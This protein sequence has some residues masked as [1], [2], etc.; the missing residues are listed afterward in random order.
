VGYGHRNVQG[1]PERPGPHVRL[2]FGSKTYDE[3]N[4]IEPGR[5]HGWPLVEA[6]APTG[7]YEPN[8][9]WTPTRIASPS[10][11]AVL[12]EH[13]YVA[14]LRGQ[15]L[16]RL[17]LDG[18]N[19]RRLL[20]DYGRLRT[21][22]VAPDGSLW[23]TTSN[24]DQ[25]CREGRAA[26]D[27]RRRPHP[28]HHTSACVAIRLSSAAVTGGRSFVVIDRPPRSRR[29]CSHSPVAF[30]DICTGTSGAVSPVV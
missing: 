6:S 25:V 20:S 29:R 10:G 18:R 27:A 5:N 22:V 2:E 4:V 14:C 21:V 12:G 3:I 16:F 9:H 7:T 11:I 17:D 8:R 26:T 1:S 15:T 13:I 24:R 30:D 19:P 28:P 23:V